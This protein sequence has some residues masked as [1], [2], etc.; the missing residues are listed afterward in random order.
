MRD[1]Y[2][3]DIREK[4]V[5]TGKVKELQAGSNPRGKRSPTLDYGWFMPN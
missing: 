1:E 3:Q 5:C 4:L 2:V